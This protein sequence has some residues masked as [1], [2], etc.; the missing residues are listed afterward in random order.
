MNLFCES[1]VISYLNLDRLNRFLIL[2]HKPETEA[3][4]QLS[5]IFFLWEKKDEGTDETIMFAI[6]FAPCLIIHPLT[7]EDGKVVFHC[8]GRGFRD[9]EQTVRC[10]RCHWA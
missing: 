1:L 2:L 8:G 9:E 4:V 3:A 10:L 7:G 6:M 5:S